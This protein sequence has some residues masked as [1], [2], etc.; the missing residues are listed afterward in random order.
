MHICER[1]LFFTRPQLAI[2]KKRVTQLFL[3]CW[4]CNFYQ[5]FKEQTFRLEHSTWTTSLWL[6]YCTPLAL[7]SSLSTVDKCSDHALSRTFFAPIG[8]FTQMHCQTHSNG[9][10]LRIALSW[11]LSLVM[12]FERSKRPFWNGSASFSIVIITAFIWFILFHFDDWQ[13]IPLWNIFLFN[14]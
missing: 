4:Y 13:H 12:L 14:C 6:N 9:L 8:K 1:I 5:N 2:K 3:L 11:G 7:C 10:S